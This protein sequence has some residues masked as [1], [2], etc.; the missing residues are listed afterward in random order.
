MN[1]WAWTHRLG[2]GLGGRKDCL[3]SESMAQGS[4]F[5]FLRTEDVKLRLLT[6]TGFAAV[7]FNIANVALKLHSWC[8]VG[9]A[10]RVP[11]VVGGIT[12]R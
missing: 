2:C 1:L 8:S 6:D 9:G 11:L 7:D 10:D 12:P 4:L 3:D 5:R